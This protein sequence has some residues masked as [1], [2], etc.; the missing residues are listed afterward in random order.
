[1]AERRFLGGKELFATAVANKLSE[2]KSE[3]VPDFSRTVIV[4]PGKIARQ[5]LRKELLKLFPEGLFLPR[6][7][8][9]HGLLHFENDAA[10]E[11]IS[12]DAEVILWGKAVNRALA[13]KEHFPLLFR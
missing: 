8:T 6:L 10:Q 9:P 11:K 13:E 2:L 3:K 4:L 12:A 5:N 7:T 1:M